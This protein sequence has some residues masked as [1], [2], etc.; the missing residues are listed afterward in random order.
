VSVQVDEPWHHIPAI[1]THIEHLSAVRF[2]DAVLDRRYASIR[3]PDVSPPIDASARVQYVAVFQDEL[4]VHDVLLSSA[5]CQGRCGP[6]WTPAAHCRE[7]DV[8]WY[9][10]H[11]VGLTDSMKLDT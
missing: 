8:T 9:A 5:G 10:S 2:G 4:I 11:F 3:D 1:A 6:G 7:Q